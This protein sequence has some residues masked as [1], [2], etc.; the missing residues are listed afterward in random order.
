MLIDPVNE[1]P[2]LP[3]DTF[4]ENCPLHTEQDDKI[5]KTR[6]NFI[7]LFQARHMLPDDCVS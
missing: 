3:K 2:D 4:S 1:E 6:N 7:D 5:I